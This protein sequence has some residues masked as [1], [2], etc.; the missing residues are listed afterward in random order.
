MWP[1]KKKKKNFEFT[2]E[3]QKIIDKAKEY[4][5]VIRLGSIKIPKEN[6]N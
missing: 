3:E 4:D 5:G 6:S 1:F 2:P